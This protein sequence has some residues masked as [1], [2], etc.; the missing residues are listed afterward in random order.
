MFCPLLRIVLKKK[1]GGVLISGIP[2]DERKEGGA[3]EK[4]GAL[5]VI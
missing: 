5:L 1:G 3:E 4:L 2:I